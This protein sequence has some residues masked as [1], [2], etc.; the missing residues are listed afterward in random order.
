[1]KK[2][3]LLLFSLLTMVSALN[4][5][6]EGLAAIGKSDLRSYMEFFASDYMGGRETGTPA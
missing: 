2:T 6:K 5:Q 4:A 3:G 1:M